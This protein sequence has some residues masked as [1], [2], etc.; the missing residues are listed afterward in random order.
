[1]A[2]MMA[3]SIEGHLEQLFHMFAYLRIKHNSSMVFD[4]TEPDIDDSQ[5]VCEEWSASVYGECKGKLP[6][7]I[8][9]QR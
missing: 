5:F 9:N 7:I 1:M 3:M 6:P 8:H 4:P 2:S